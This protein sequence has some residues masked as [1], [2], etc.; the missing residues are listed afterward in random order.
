MN[1]TNFNFKSASP[2]LAISDE[3]QIDKALSRSHRIHISA[4]HTATKSLT[5]DLQIVIST[6]LTFLE[7]EFDKCQLK[8][9]NVIP[10]ELDF[11]VAIQIV[12]IHQWVV[13]GGDYYRR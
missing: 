10:G 13:W 6:S 8:V 7:V 11:V 1:L 9:T 12:L 3:L 2:H 4:N 5:P